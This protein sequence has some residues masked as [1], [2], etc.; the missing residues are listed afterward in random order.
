[1]SVSFQ[2]LPLERQLFTDLL[3][4][5]DTEL[6]RLGARRMVVDA[7]PGFPCRVSL[8]DATIGERVVLTPFTHHDVDSPYQASGPI[9]VRENADT[10]ELAVDEI[11]KMLE[12]RAL[13]VR[14]YDDD[15]MM[16]DARIVNG[17][18]LPVVIPE[19]LD[20]PGVDYLH[21]HNAGPGCFNCSVRAV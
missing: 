10:T 2:V 5:D 19:L 13:S 11:P 3:A 6:A 8:E 14:A 18:E 4:M 16:I 1:M 17:S 12:H 9:F 21:I 15:A 20:Q 7:H